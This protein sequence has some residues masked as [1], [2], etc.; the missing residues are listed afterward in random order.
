MNEPLDQAAGTPGEAATPRRRQWMVIAALTAAATVMF[1]AL[2]MV[3][4]RN[5]QDFITRRDDSV[6]DMLM[7]EGKR[8][9]GSSAFSQALATYERALKARFNGP[10]NRTYTLEHAGLLLWKEGRYEEAAE[11][12]TR[13]LNGPGATSAPYEGLVDSL[14]HLKRLDEA[15]GRLDEWKARPDAAAEQAK[16]CYAA[17]RLA[18]SRNEIQ[19]AREIYAQCVEQHQGALSA[20]RLGELL[21]ESGDRD[22]AASYLEQYFLLG[23]PGRNNDALRALYYRLL[24]ETPGQ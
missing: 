12:F 4:A 20:G 15:Q 13:G 16:I 2:C 22:K 1:L 11:H 19:Q 6:G 3:F 23:A 14:I 8:Q 17:G 5:G 24:D 18:E 9:E 10:E 21:A 7:R